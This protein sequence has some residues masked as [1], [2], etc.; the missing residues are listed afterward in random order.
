MQTR[1]VVLKPLLHPN[2]KSIDSYPQKKSMIRTAFLR[3]YAQLIYGAQ[4][5][6]QEI[7]N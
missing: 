1:E 5:I 7:L 3:V 2:F 6:S 4:T